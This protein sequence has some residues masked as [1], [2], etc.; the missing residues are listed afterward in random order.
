MSDREVDVLRLLA[1]GRSMRQI[2][3]T[4]F[5]SVSTVHTH[6]AHIYEKA[7]VSTR[8]SAALFAMENGLV[9]GASASL[10]SA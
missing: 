6:T 10:S 8:A 3:E 7:G 2:A 9:E 4:L 1:R 5:I